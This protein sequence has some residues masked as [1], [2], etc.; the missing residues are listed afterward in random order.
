MQRCEVY[1]R[2]GSVYVVSQ[3]Y[4]EY[5]IGVSVGPMFKADASNANEI[6]EAIVAALN[7]SRE[8]IPPPTDMKQ[9]QKSLFQF[10]GAKNWADL[11]RTAAYV[12]VKR[13]GTRV[14]VVP[15]KIGEQGAYV[16]DGPAVPTSG[17]GVAEIGNAVISV[18]TVDR[19]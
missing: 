11:L 2:K 8:N 12:A 1:L 16:P 18:L 6:G 15:H 4:T 7:A 5:G 17:A 19:H 3:S 14:T 10:T 9:I 13:D